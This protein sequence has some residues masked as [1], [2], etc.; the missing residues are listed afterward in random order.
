MDS[1]ENNKQNL[2]LC[3]R[4][5][6][7]SGLMTGLT[8]EYFTPFI[9]LLGAA[10]RHVGLLN[11]LPNFFAALVQIKG[12]ETV[13]RLRSR[14]RVVA[15]FSSLQAVTLAMLCVMALA[16]RGR[17]GCRYHDRDRVHLLRGHG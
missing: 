10:A 11:A 7:F 3:Y 5:G 4:N 8:Q 13:D 2:G 17:P 9:L 14:K 1:A 6:L 16:G 12:A 15:L